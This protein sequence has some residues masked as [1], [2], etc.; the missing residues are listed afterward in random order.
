MAATE[1]F[2]SL[3]LVRSVLTISKRKYAT[4]EEACRR[5]EKWLASELLVE[6]DC[7]DRMRPKMMRS[8]NHFYNDPQAEYDLGLELDEEPPFDLRCS[9]LFS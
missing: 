2:S 6:K 4:Q 7:V 3:V 1:G 5:A 9:R 8:L